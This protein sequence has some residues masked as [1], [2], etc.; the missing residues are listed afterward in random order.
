[1]N[2]IL[3]NGKMRVENQTKTR[4]WEDPRL[5][6]EASTKNAVQEFHF[7]TCFFIKK[8][9]RKGNLVIF[10]TS[11]LGLPDDL[12]KL[13]HVPHQI[14]VDPLLVQHYNHVHL[15]FTHTGSQCCGSGMFIP[16]PGSWFLPIPDP[17]FRI[18]D[19]GSKNRNKREGWKKICFQ[20]FFCSHKFHKNVNYFIFQCWRIFKES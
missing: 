8:S 19:P 12:D 4:V 14:V 5:C 1:M 6:P 7:G 11:G 17:G 18:S 2:G 15:T 10:L 16:D 13:G 9:T 3:L 20:T